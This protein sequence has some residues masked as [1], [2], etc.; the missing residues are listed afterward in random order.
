MVAP[1]SRRPYSRVRLLGR[2]NQIRRRGDD[3]RRAVEDR[4]FD[5]QARV[6]PVEPLPRRVPPYGRDDEPVSGSIWGEAHSAQFVEDEVFLRLEMDR[7]CHVGLKY[8]P[9]SISRE[10]RPD[11]RPL[12][13]V[14]FDRAASLAEQHPGAIGMLDDVW[15]RVILNPAG[16]DLSEPHGNLLSPYQQH[17][18]FILERA[19]DSSSTVSPW[20]L[21]SELR[22]SPPAV[23]HPE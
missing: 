9:R 13:A 15:C 22:S 1:L 7:T 12:N 6:Q 16:V 19:I 2:I 4:V 18:S 11:D 21:S 20:H 8:V 3:G 23:M 17:S 14:P 10:I 5:T